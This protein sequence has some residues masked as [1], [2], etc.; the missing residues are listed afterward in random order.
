MSASD[1]ASLDIGFIDPA[2]LSSLTSFHDLVEKRFNQRIHRVAS[3]AV[4][5]GAF[6]LMGRRR[7]D[8]RWTLPGGSLYRYENPRSGAIRELR[9]EAGI[10]GYQVEPLCDEISVKMNGEPVRVF[11]FRMK[12]QGIRP[13]TAEYDPDQEVEE[14]RWV[15]CRSGLPDEIRNALHSP[16]DVVLRE[17]G[18]L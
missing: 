8:Q 3:V 11:G 1:Q 17:L 10:S 4:I 15:D 9:E 12:I 18:L 6:L 7:D 5:A 13:V 14:W 16:R 2:R